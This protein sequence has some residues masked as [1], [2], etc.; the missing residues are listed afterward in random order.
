M[1]RRV[2]IVVFVLAFV[3]CS[4]ELGGLYFGGWGRGRVVHKSWRGGCVMCVFLG[5]RYFWADVGDAFEITYD[6]HIIDG[7]FR[8]WLPQ[9]T[10]N[11]PRD[12]E[13]AKIT[14]SGRGVWRAP[15]SRRGWYRLVVTG[16]GERNGYDVRFRV[17]W[18]IDRANRE[19][20]GRG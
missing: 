12:T 11:R 19:Q 13:S 5:S 14:T 10:P 7:A 4:V 18:R 20:I 3:L 2:G 1:K 17:N 8:M 9:I 16:A 6:I 15:I